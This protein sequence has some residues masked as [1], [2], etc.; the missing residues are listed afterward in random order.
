MSRCGQL[1]QITYHSD[2]LC[3][4]NEKMNKNIQMEYSCQST[5]FAADDH[6]YITINNYVLLN[7]LNAIILRTRKKD[8]IT[9]F[10]RPNFRIYELISIY[11]HLF[12][13][14]QSIGIPCRIK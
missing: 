14:C 3:W 10:S 6:R 2:N 8:I 11:A 1:A 9:D 7:F 12:C 13:I 4:K 5:T